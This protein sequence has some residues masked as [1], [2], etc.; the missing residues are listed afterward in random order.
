[1]IKRV[2]SF[3]SPAYLS[4]SNEQLLI[5]LADAPPPPTS[6]YAPPP[7]GAQQLPT[8][9]PIADLGVVLLDHPQ[10]TITHAA[11]AALLQYQVAVVVCDAKHHP[12][13]LLLPL[14][15]HTL[16][17]AY[18]RNQIEA[19]E[20]LKKNLWQQTIKAKI[21][22]Q[23]HLLQ[24]TANTTPDPLRRWA[25]DVLSGDTTN[26]EARAAAYY[27]QHLFRHLPNFFRGRQESPPNHLLNY[28]YAILRALT[29][30]SLVCS[31]L[32]PTLGIHHR[33]QYNAYC[34]ADDIMEPYRPF[35][36]ALIL[37]IT[38]HGSQPDVPLSPTTKKTL[39]QLP[40]LD[41]VLDGN[42]S[43][44]MLAMQRTTASLAQ[45]FDKSKR[46]ILYPS[47]A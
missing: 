6:R 44:L 39:L 30:R 34:L 5:Q 42:T 38:Q 4:T 12:S 1:M 27:W 23:A 21:T 14:D 47:F 33:N 3:G 35:V 7:H 46:T 9:L 24:Q 40:T 25:A 16:Q 22:N 26:L 41:V 32:L 36:D 28:G 45:C 37:R 31:G 17:S 43:P 13:G 11:L 19:S 20:P 18:F 29:A 2:V 15:G 10:I 8:S